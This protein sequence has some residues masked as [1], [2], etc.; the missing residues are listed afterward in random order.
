MENITAIYLNPEKTWFETHPY[1]GSWHPIIMDTKDGLDYSINI[2][3]E[4]YS[5]VEN[6]ELNLDEMNDEECNLAFEE[7][8]IRMEDLG[9]VFKTYD[10]YVNNVIDKLFKD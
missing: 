2:Y 1:N 7:F 4:W 9:F 3:E 5:F 10:E 6:E 8:C